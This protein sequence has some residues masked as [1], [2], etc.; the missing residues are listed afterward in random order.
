M[1]GRWGCI[2]ASPPWI[3]KYKYIASKYVYKYLNFVLE[4][5]SSTSMSTKYYNSAS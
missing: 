2:L 4:Y 5:Y 1:S 3:R